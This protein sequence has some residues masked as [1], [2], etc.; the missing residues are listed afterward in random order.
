[1]NTTNSNTNDNEQ[2]H[3]QH[4]TPLFGSMDLPVA[5]SMQKRYWPKAIGFM[6]TERFVPHALVMSTRDTIWP[7]P[8]KCVSTWKEANRVVCMLLEQTTLSSPEH[9]KLYYL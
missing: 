8:Q 1:M 6:C 3:P 4:N 7:I 5:S 2:Q 9:D